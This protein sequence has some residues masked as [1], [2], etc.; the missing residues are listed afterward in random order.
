MILIR[1]YQCFTGIKLYKHIKLTPDKLYN[2]ISLLHPQ[3]IK[4]EDFAH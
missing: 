2:F 1:E 4:V 3:E